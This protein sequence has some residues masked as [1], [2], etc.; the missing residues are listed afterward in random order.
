MRLSLEA[1]C[2]EP[3]PGYGQERAE[4]GTLIVAGEAGGGVMSHDESRGSKMPPVLEDVSRRLV[5]L[6]PRFET[7]S[8]AFLQSVLANVPDYIAMVAPDGTIA[9]VNRVREGSS[10]DAVLGKSVF[11]FTMPDHVASYRSA[12][13]HVS[14]TGEPCR[15]EQE[16]KLSDGSVAW[17]ETR[18]EPIRERGEVIAVLVIA[19]DVSQRKR[20]DK[21]LRES[22]AKVRMSVDAAGIG[23]WSWNT[24]TDHVVWEGAMAQ[25]FGV[26]AGSA[27]AGRDGYLAL[28]HTED[29]ERVALAIER[30]VASGRWEDVYRIVR[31]DGAVRWIL[32]NGRSLTDPQGDVVLGSVIDIT[33][34]RLLD[35]Q[36]RQSQKLE[37]VG[38]LTAGIAHNFNN[39]LMGIVPNVEI[40]LRDAPPSIAPRLCDA[41]A[42]AQRAADLVR[43]LMTYAGRNRPVARNTESIGALVERTVDM[44]RATF[45]RRISLETRYD[46]LASARVDPSQ[47]EQVVLNI[48]INAR[49]ALMAR[50]NAMPWITVGVDIVGEG[51][52]P[53]R[54]APPGPRPQEHVRIRISDNG[55]GM[56]SATLGRIYEPFFTTKGP[57]SGTGLGLATSHAIVRDHG[58]WIECQ[59]APEVGT[60][61]A[62]Y[63]PADGA[64]TADELAR[65]SPHPRGG[66]ET[67]LIVD[68]EPAVRRVVKLMLESAGY[69]VHTAESGRSAI[70]VLSDRQAADAVGAIL[71]DVSMPGMPRQELRE[72][73]RQMVPRARV[74]YF[75]GH[76]F[77]AT[78]AQDAVLEKPVTEE[79][80]LRVVREVLD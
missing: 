5:A 34:R 45:D 8:P 65:P 59:S 48:L 68:D 25:I 35:E 70:Q 62:V 58:G 37:A 60:T 51:A 61:F 43:Q 16:A 53:F 31:S 56:D 17:F 55:V 47:I 23:L 20:A 76:A 66:A 69:T 28:V 30:G 4:R 57:G 10:F 78:D 54:A 52:P 26:P 63:L 33:E 41:A 67:I 3:V 21:A 13:D 29:R 36:V 74:I 80:L 12:L 15:L 77:E 49:D 6:G 71:L 79:T 50:H 2:L 44:C 75:T 18:L 14:R 42:S 19:T 22:E 32:V 46:L 72:R 38:R 64:A 1:P 27:P 39:M 40:A 24:A 11:D 9:F 7:H 73:L